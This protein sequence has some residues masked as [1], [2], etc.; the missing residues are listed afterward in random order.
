MASLGR[1]MLSSSKLQFYPTDPIETYRIAGIVGD[2]QLEY[3]QFPRFQEELKG[4]EAAA[5]ER[6]G[7]CSTYQTM[8]LGRRFLFFKLAEDNR[9]EDLAQLFKLTLDTQ[10]SG[11]GFKH[12][13]VVADLFAGEGEFLNVFGRLAGESVLLIANEV[14]QNRYEKIKNSKYIGEAHNTAFEDFQMPKHCVGV[15][16]FNP[17]Y[18]SINGERSAVQY[19]KMIL[20]RELL[21]PSY[22]SS[23]S[24][25][26]FVLRDDDLKKCVPI[27]TQHFNVVCLYRANDQAFK[28]FICIAKLKEKPLTKTFYDVA[29]HMADMDSLNRQIAENQ[30]F[31]QVM[32]HE[33]VF[34]YESV[35]YAMA[36]NNFKIAKTATRVHSDPNDRPWQF[37][38]QLTLLKDETKL[39]LVMPRAPK[40]GEI[41]NLLAAGQ[42]NSEVR[43]ED[44]CGDHVV[45]GGTQVV[46]TVM[47][48]ESIG[49]TKTE[50]S[51]IIIKKHEPYLNILITDENGSPRILELSESQ[52]KESSEAG[53]D[54][55]DE[56]DAE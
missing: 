7:P 48:N 12:P 29:Q 35:D 13:V 25:M 36:K 9:F 15:M 27:I 2:I 49:Q 46:E 33:E 43:F 10:P 16:L 55:E 1:E 20:G 56:V 47:R 53:P 37:I 30:P 23:A 24:V 5:Q 18:T 51:V 31:D 52:K 6:Y 28:Q 42:L 22:K 44:G 32:G 40:I 11:A 38:K 17:P 3:R 21:A 50:D 45:I 4:M 8:V 39:Q 14:E 41:S 34:K 26:V 19:L 54:Q